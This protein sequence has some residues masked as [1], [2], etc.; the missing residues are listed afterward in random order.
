VVAVSDIIKL[1]QPATVPVNEDAIRVLQDAIDRVRRGEIDAVA[2]VAI[3][4]DGSLATGW[5]SI[6]DTERMW[7]GAM[8]LAED[9]KEY[10]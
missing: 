2:F 7:H 3:Y 8:S 9:L 5:S 1:V 10:R 6:A 4:S